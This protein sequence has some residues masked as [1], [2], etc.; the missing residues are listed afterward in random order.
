LSSKSNTFAQP[1]RENKRANTP[2]EA[3]R[4]LPY[5]LRGFGAF[6][7][8]IG[9]DLRAYE[10]EI[11][12][13][14]FAG[15]AIETVCIIPKKNGKTTLLAAL[16]LY[17]VYMVPDAKCLIGASARDQATLIFWQA[18]A[19]V[20]AGGLEEVF[21][22]KGGY[23]HIRCGAAWIRVLAGDARTADGIGPTLALVDELHRHR[24]LDL[25][26]VFRDGLRGPQNGRMVT[27]STAGE[28]MDSPLGTVRDKAY[29]LE[30]FTRKGSH[31]IVRNP[32]GSFVMHEWCL[33]PEDDVENMRTVKTANPAPWI[34]PATL[35]QDRWTPSMTLGQWLRF[36]CGIWTEGDEPPIPPQMWDQARTL[37]AIEAGSPVWLGVDMGPRRD[38]TAIAIVQVRD[39]E[40]YT[41]VEILPEV[42]YAKIESRV[43]ELWGIYDVQAVVYTSKGFRR[44]ADMLEEEGLRMMEYPTSDERM[45]LAS[46]TFYKSLE[47]GKLH[48]DGDKLLRDHVMGA[49][50]KETEQGWRFR[51]D[52]QA[53]RATDGLFALAVACHIALSEEPSST[54]Q[55]VLL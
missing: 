24:S 40:V 21:D 10:R 45:T 25:Y 54:P 31:N 53:H 55:F 48:H 7:K 23:R 42:S 18:E 5:G 12:A 44:S 13:D 43:R 39:G 6:C 2:L 19:L 3:I 17:H 8:L 28:T 20:H 34:T 14:Y 4:G 22:V 47:D 15:T 33:R 46:A 9:L 32:S 29:E 1:L 38:S 35:K 26:G 37:F 50:V 27:I 16:A 30:D 51:K 11:L 41:K 49:R 52:P 36:A